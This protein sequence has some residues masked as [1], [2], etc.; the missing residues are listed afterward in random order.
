MPEVSYQKHLTPL[1]MLEFFARFQIELGYV[2]LKVLHLIGKWLYDILKFGYRRAVLAVFNLVEFCFKLSKA[3]RKL[4]Y[5]LSTQRLVIPK[6]V[7]PTLLKIKL[8]TLT[9]PKIKLPLPVT[10]KVSTVKAAIIPIKKKII[11]TPIANKR[12]LK[13]PHLYEKSIT[14][15]FAGVLCALLF[16]MLPLNIQAWARQLP[17]PDVL[18]ER[19]TSKSTK[20]LDRNGRLLYEIYEDRK[21]NPIPLEEVPEHM[22]QA[23]LAIEDDRFYSH[24]GF[25]LESIM[26]AAKASVLD[27]NLQG[28]STITQQLV[29]NVLLTPERT[30]PR[31]VKELILSVLV[32]QKYTKDEILELYLNNIPYGGTAWGIE[33]A[34][35]KFFGK[36]A[37]ELSLAE[38]A[39]LAGLPTA[40]TAYSPVTGNIGV[41]KDRQAQV[42]KR[43]VTLGYITQ[44]QADTAYKTPLE[45]APQKEFIKAPHFVAYVK[46]QLES[47][48]GKRYVTFGGLA[49][50]TTID[51]E[52]Q[53]KVQQIVAEEV[54][55]NKHL[56]I[57]NGAAVVLDPK[58]GEILAHVGSI[59][60]FAEGWGAF[61]VVTALRQ[62]GSSIKPITYALGFERGLSP[63]TV[64][65]DKPVKFVT[66][67]E[68]Y[69]PANYDGKFHGKVSLRQ[70]LANSYN[71]PAVKLV[72]KLGPDNM[73]ALGGDMGLPGWEIDS[74]YGL[75]VTLGGK[76]VTLLSLANAYGV[77]A[78]GGVYKETTPF[79]SVLDSNGYE[80]YS[81]ADTSGTN[82]EE[83]RVLS[84]G[85]AYLISH[86]LSDSNARLPAFG[87]NNF[88]DI[89]G[90]KV[91]VKTG[92]TDNKRDNW[93]VGYTPSVVVGVWV[94]NNDNSP[95][96]QRL[97]SGL[98]GAA[99]IWNRIMRTVLNGKPN[100]DFRKPGNVFVKHDKD[101]G[102]SEIFVEG[103]T[104]PERLCPK[105]EEKDVDK[106]EENY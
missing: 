78:R 105:V 52:L 27:D 30:I 25:R 50:T 16:I 38:T 67:T 104:V 84:E 44:E 36:S 4:Q 24:Y 83:T 41:S 3:S 62:P 33:S 79:L 17:N 12:N 43:M 31:K 53:E 88:L 20:I 73:V 76:E 65:E 106:E 14:L 26:R 81:G 95:M 87:T 48:Y 56:N 101:C 92:T 34:A 60:Y 97:A 66:P 19:G 94:G 77:F 46:K 63:A 28:A 71:I 9:L 98:S 68:I 47:V 6:L 13:R 39:L 64:I 91:A 103:M 5:K 82:A 75:S 90:H 86:I 102:R 96:N 85:T 11:Y 49:V 57:N 93:T 72:E 61:D 23:T 99:P 29:K 35:Q 7:L 22:L 70:A 59:D 18:I 42:L 89:P 1:R 32:E 8:S 2:L 45:F 10:P 69:K 55:K 37:K 80:M 40:P 58:T 100:E 21:Y 15:F 51:L 74:S 54:E